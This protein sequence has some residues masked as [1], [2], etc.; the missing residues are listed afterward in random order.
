M[1]DE[2]TQRAEDVAWLKGLPWHSRQTGTWH[3]EACSIPPEGLPLDRLVRL[4]LEPTPGVRIRYDDWEYVI[5]VKGWLYRR[6][7]FPIE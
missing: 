7:G 6:W 3:G 4:G 1:N 5:S 2:D